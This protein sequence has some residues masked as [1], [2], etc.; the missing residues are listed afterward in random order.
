MR[1]PILLVRIS[2]LSD[3]RGRGTGDLG[4]WGPGSSFPQRPCDC[5][6]GGQQGG[7]S[8]HEYAENLE[9]RIDKRPTSGARGAQVRARQLVDLDNAERTRGGEEEE[10][11]TSRTQTKSKHLGPAGGQLVDRAAGGARRAQVRAGQL[12][13]PDDAGRKSARA[14]SARE[15][16]WPAP[17]PR[18]AEDT[19]AHSAARACR[20]PPRP[21]HGPPGKG[22]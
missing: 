9:Y 19:D 15:P 6:E 10:E 11:E 8:R 12:V 14:A 3:G 16:P 2:P 4:T 18:V 5:T 22:A 21:R 1:N 20:R 17:A 13:D 7:V